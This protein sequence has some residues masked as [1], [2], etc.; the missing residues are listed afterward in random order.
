MTV[1]LEPQASIPT[2]TCF[3]FTITTTPEV[4]RPDGRRKSRINWEAQ[5]DY[6]QLPRRW[7]WMDHSTAV[8]N[9]RFEQFAP[10]YRGR[11]VPE[12][13]T[14]SEREGSYNPRRGSFD[15]DSIHDIG[16]MCRSDFGKQEGPFRLTILK[17][18]AV[19]RAERPLTISG[20]WGAILCSL[21]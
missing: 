2:P 11:P 16:I 15:T 3:T 14:K 8:I 1:A 13:D 6:A 12:D 17:I 20:K 19:E 4:M 7:P 10:F 9:L 18:E 21:I 5:F